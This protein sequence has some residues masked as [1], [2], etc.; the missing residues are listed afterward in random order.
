MP[1]SSV[2]R[3]TEIWCLVGLAVAVIAPY[4]YKFLAYPCYVI[5]LICAA[6]DADD[7]PTPNP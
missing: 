6:I 7:N 1:I 2:L 3:S 5:A 4:P